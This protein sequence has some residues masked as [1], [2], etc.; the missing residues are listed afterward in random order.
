MTIINL[1]Q[2]QATA[3]QLQ[4]GVVDLPTEQRTKLIGLLTFEEIPTPD[5]I[6]ERAKSIVDLTDSLPMAPEKAMIGGAPYLI[7]YLVEEL[8]A[9]FIQSVYSFTKRVSVESTSPTGEVT[10]TAVFRHVGFVNA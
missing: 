6:Q 8:K 1:T 7:P 9:A 5:E 4:A 10:K 3:E 2:H